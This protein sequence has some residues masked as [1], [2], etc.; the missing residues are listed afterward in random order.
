M[1]SLGRNL[2]SIV[3]ARKLENDEKKKDSGLSVV[4]AQRKTIIGRPVSAHYHNTSTFFSSHTFDPEP[5]RIT[6][7]PFTKKAKHFPNGNMAE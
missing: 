4:F 3:Y 6:C 7:T 5:S 1:E 2:I